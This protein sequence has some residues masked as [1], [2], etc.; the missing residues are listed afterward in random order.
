MKV[1]PFAAT[2]AALAIAAAAPAHA[3][4]QPQSTTQSV[5]FAVNAINQISFTGSPSLTIA[6]LP[7]GGGS[8]TATD[9]TSTWAITS[10][11]TGSKV[12]GSLSAAMPSNLTLAVQLGAPTGATSTGMTT[13]TTAPVDLV[14]GISNAASSGL[15][16]TYH[17]TATAA[18]APGSGTRVVTYTVS[19]GT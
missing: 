1:T 8:T 10:N 2:L 16:V 15:A 4:A 18:A 12:T 19:G 5:S 13:L 3:Q 6:T 14:T 7:T 9:A 17:L 11:Q